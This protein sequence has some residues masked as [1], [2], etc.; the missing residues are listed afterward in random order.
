MVHIKLGTKTTFY[1]Q[2]T[3]SDKLKIEIMNNSA[4]YDKSARIFNFTTH[5]TGKNIPVQSISSTS[6]KIF[7]TK[8]ETATSQKFRVEFGYLIRRSL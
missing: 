5:I 6:T 3:F 2:N 8:N 4:K 1:K 7:K